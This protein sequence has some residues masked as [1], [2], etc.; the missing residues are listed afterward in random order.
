MW[1]RFQVLLASLIWASNKALSS[2]D[3]PGGDLARFDIPM[4]FGL[5]IDTFP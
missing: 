1:V 5:G 2:R 3:T 4:A